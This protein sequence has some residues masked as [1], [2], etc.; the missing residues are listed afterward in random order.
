MEASPQEP[1][2]Q[3][4]DLAAVSKKQLVEFL[5]QHGNNAFLQKHRLKG[6]VA[7]IQKSSS[8]KQ[9]DDAY[10]D[11]FVS[12]EFRTEN[13]D[14]EAADVAKRQAN[15]AAHPKSTTA[16]TST[17]TEKTAEPQLKGYKRRVTKR[18]NGHTPSVGETVKVRY[19]GS[20]EDGT[21]FDTN[22]GRG[23]PILQFKVGKGEVIRGWDE[24]VLE[25]SVGEKAT[26]T[27]EPEWAYGAK[28]VEGKI[29][30][31]ATLIFE[32]ELESIL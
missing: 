4:T 23:K 11:L 10:E 16:A 3:W 30:P 20:L 32:V 13:D 8:K 1:E 21:I 17:A 7:N 25:M 19:R 27:I 24:G 18:G 22:I 5:Q 28:G 2:R 26:I 29:P 6:K 31:N 15:R 14:K 9:L 12:K